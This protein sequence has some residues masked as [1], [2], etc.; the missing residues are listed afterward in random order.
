MFF[1]LGLALLQGILNP[2]EL[3]ESFNPTAF[4]YTAPP[5]RHPHFEGKQVVV[6]NRQPGNYEL[7]SYNLYPGPSAKK[8]VYG[9]LNE[10]KS[11]ELSDLG[12]RIIECCLDGGTVEDYEKLTGVSHS[13]LAL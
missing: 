13:H 8:G 5:F 10:F 2:D 12:N 7:F 11:P 6:H 9:M 1:G 3:D 4:I